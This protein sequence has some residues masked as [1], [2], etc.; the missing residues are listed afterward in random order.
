VSDEPAEEGSGLVILVGAGPGDPDLLTLAGA[1]ALRTAD[2]VLY[3]ELLSHGILERVPETVECINVGKR[4]HAAPTRSQG[5]INRLL[6]E[7]ALQGKRVV[8]L[9]GGDPFVFGRGGEEASACRAAGVRFEVVPG[10]SSAIA[11][12]T[13]AG[14]PITDRRHAASFAVVT[15]HKDPTRVSEATRWQ[16]LG[17]AV[18][19]LVILMG[20]RTLPELVTKLIDGGK[21]PKTPAAAVMNGTLPQQRVVEAALEDLPEA[22]REAELGSPS[23]VVIGDVV[24]LRSELK[25]V[26]EQPLRGLRVLVTRAEAQSQEMARSIEWAGGEARVMPMIALAPAEDLAP[27]DAAV[28]RLEDYDFLAFTSANAVRYFV[29]R[30]EELGCE[31][32]LEQLAAQVMCVGLKTAQAA[33]RAGLHVSFEASSRGDAQ[34]MLDE[35][36]AGF[37]LV[38]HRVL[39]PRSAIARNVL[40]EGLRVAGALV[41][42]VD[43][44]RNL[45]PSVDA[46]LLRAELVGGELH[47]LTFASPSAVRHFASLLDEEARAAVSRCVVAAMGAA[48]SDALREAG[49]E[50]A[51]VPARPS[52]RDL[53]AAV[54]V[55]VRSLGAAPGRG[56]GGGR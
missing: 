5:E 47:V 32:A 28:T 9:K 24:R 30:V 16:E 27:L 12:L 15:G 20:M 42:D 1:E 2:V 36:K 56:T 49:F 7:L 46:P 25:W 10:V 40:S 41:D 55:H 14:I 23:A 43:T 29:S 8:R 51:V 53:I 11:A 45:R 6:V 17:S 34:S 38:G 52:G 4:G 35:L 33:R 31:Q 21:D 3:D 26:D 48:T 39:I 50:P 54:I 19:T 18:D 13:Y 37:D 22:V 44:Y